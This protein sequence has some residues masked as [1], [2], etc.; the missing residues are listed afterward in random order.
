MPGF[1]APLAGLF[2]GGA[3][4]KIGAHALT[5][6]GG[7]AAWEGVSRLLHGSVEDQMRKQMEIGEKLEAERAAKMGGQPQ[8][9]E[10]SDL[11]DL[12]AG[13]GRRSLTDL[14][15]EDELLRE[16]ARGAKSMERFRRQRPYGSREL[17]DIL[18]GQEARIAALQ[19]ERGV[20]PLEVI[21]MME[22]MG[23]A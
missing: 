16:V 21:Q 6:L 20:T 11:N 23:D 5:T 1:I 4:A 2:S 13:G 14:M 9:G 22:A 19:S 15:E 8:Y 18:A 12:V 3:A 10:P 17:N 7:I